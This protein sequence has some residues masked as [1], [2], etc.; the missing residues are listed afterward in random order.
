MLCFRK[1]FAT[2][3]IYWIFDSSR[4]G[5]FVEVFCDARKCFKEHWILFNFFAAFLLTQLDRHYISRL[6]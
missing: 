6:F 4:A 2:L 3:K 5:D 1:R